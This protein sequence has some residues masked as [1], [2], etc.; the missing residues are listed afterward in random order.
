M[1]QAM[2]AERP[3]RVAIPEPDPR[4]VESRIRH[5]QRL[6]LGVGDIA[7]ATGASRAYVREAMERH[8][9]ER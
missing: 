9:A 6:G 2:I 7:Y 3:R 1:R 5:L 8:A 4:Q